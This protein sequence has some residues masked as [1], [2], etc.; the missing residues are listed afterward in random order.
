MGDLDS[1]RRGAGTHPGGVPGEVRTAVIQTGI[2]APGIGAY[3]VDGASALY[4]RDEPLDGC[5]R[6]GRSAQLPQAEG[7]PPPSPAGHQKLLMSRASAEVYGAYT[8]RDA[9]EQAPRRSCYRDGLRMSGMRGP[10]G[11]PPE[12]Q[13]SVASRTEQTADQQ[14]ERNEV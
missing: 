6:L 7:T 12:A 11:E 5:V 1:S 13:R 9:K 10:S 3:G 4:T 2:A 8:F 14:V